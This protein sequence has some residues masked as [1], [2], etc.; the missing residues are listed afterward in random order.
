MVQSNTKIF[1]S[2][3]R[4]NTTHR[5][6]HIKDRIVTLFGDLC[7]F[8]NLD[9]IPAGMDF[10]TVPEK[11]T[12]DCKIRLLMIGSDWTNLAYPNREKRNFGPSRLPTH[13]ANQTHI[14][15]G[16]FDRESSTMRFGS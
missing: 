3:G 13:Y 14:S 4:V 5:I 6:G 15:T 16:G 1:F 9:D 12:N 2:C 7:V 8:R 11:E 10:R